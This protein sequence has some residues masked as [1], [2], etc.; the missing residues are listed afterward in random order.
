MS[1]Y[2]VVWDADVESAFIEAWIADDSDVRAL[3][4]LIAQLV[5]SNLCDDPDQKGVAWLDQ[6]IRIWA[7]P[8]S[9][10]SSRVSVTYRVLADDR[11]VRVIR[12]LISGK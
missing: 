5:D 9:N 6:G 2:T 11:Q 1:R 7:V 8:V 3:L 10:S 4:T 12:L